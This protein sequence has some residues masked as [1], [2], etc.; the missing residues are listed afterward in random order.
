M[1]QGS[2][3]GLIVEDSD[4][5][6]TFRRR[7]RIAFLRQAG[8][9]EIIIEVEQPESMAAPQRS[10]LDYTGSNLVGATYGIVQ[11]LIATNNFELKPNFI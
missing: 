1:T 5:E 7:L 9:V 3:S 8:L 4:I 2:P 6:L 10:I 11:H